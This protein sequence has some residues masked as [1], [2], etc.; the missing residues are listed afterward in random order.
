M[1]ITMTI[2]DKIIDEKFQKDM[3]RKAAKISAL[4]LDKIDKYESLTGEEILP[5]D[6]SRL[7]EETKTKDKNKKKQLKVESKKNI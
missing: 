6:Q 1:K 7:I 2:N 5:F 4:S 3:D